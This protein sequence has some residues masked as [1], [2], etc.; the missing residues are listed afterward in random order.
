MILRGD[1]TVYDNDKKLQF[2]GVRIC[3]KTKLE[4]KERGLVK[5]GSIIIRIFEE[6]V[7]ITT[8]M[9]LVVGLCGDEV[10]PSRAFI[11]T[12]VKKNKGIGRLHYKVIAER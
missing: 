7:S 10:C 4:T 6:N 2:S 9:R 1:I 3:D 12:D 11:V 5:S 8:R